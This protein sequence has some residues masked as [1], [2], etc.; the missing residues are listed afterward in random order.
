MR[1]NIARFNEIKERLQVD[2]DQM[3]VNDAL[4]EL[5]G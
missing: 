5:L 1:L 2:P 4:K 3:F